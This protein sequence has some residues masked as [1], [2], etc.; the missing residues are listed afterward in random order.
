MNVRT[1]ALGVVVTFVV[2]VA[3]AHAQGPPAGGPGA[4]ASLAAR[5]DALEARVAALETLDENDIVG[6]YQA[7]HLGIELNPGFLNGPPARVS[8]SESSFVLQL[9]ADHSVQFVEGK[10]LGCTL[11]A[12]ALGRVEC[13]VPEEEE[14]QTEPTTWSMANG[15]LTISAGDGDLLVF[16]LAANGVFVAADSSEFQPGHGWAV[17]FVLTKLAN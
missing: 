15:M 3:G 1:V 9:N 2:G 10:G 4:G 11:E 6:R 14:E 12:T 5:I 7:I 13:E 17:V 8:T 16:R